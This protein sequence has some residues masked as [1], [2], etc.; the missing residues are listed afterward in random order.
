MVL[1]AL[2]A[3][4]IAL[5]LVALTRL[6]R[7][8]K[9]NTAEVRELRLTA[10]TRISTVAVRTGA[11][12]EDEVKLRQLRRLGRQ[13]QGKRVIVGGD[14]LSDQHQQLARQVHSDDDS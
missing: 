4:L 1:W 11:N 5:A 13:T 10:R 9:E 12:A 8:I 14:E 2:T 7:T 6:G 3:I